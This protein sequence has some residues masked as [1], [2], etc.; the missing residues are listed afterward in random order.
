MAPNSPVASLSLGPMNKL[1]D[2]MPRAG[3]EYPDRNQV[4]HE[5]RRDK[6][7]ATA[8]RKAGYPLSKEGL[9]DAF[10]PMFELATPILAERPG[11]DIFPDIWLSL[12]I[13]QQDL[14]WAKPLSTITFMDLFVSLVRTRSMWKKNQQ[15]PFWRTWEYDPLVRAIIDF[16]VAVDDCP[17]DKQ[18]EEDEDEDYPKPIN[19]D[20]SY[21]DT[22]VE[23]AFEAAF[24]TAVETAAE[25][26]DKT[27][28][29][30]A[31]ETAG[32]P[33]DIDG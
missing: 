33:M 2:I 11:P 29:E 7:I 1:G 15:E 31:D 20:E 27:A 4:T 21:D 17:I 16:R 9:R 32:D 8:L 12:L 18:E 5:H 3:M 22:A 24:G 19:L 10:M 30:T 23:S 25:T 14:D 28:A 6:I 26:T 13:V